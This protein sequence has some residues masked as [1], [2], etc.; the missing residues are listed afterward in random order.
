MVHVDYGQ[1]GEC[2]EIKS[3]DERCVQ[4]VHRPNIDEGYILDC[5]KVITCERRYYY[6][7]DAM[8]IV[9][10]LICDFFQSTFPRALIVAQEVMH[11]VGRVRSQG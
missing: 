6:V 1:S 2:V 7:E 11:A 3:Y 9:Y 4:R 5:V 10:F 8:M